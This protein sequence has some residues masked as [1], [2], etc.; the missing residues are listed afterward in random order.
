MNDI[1][2]ALERIYKW[3]EANLPEAASDLQPGLNSNEIN[4]KMSNIS[5]SLPQ[6]IYEI[7]SWRNGNIQWLR[8]PILGL[9]FPP[10]ETA[11]NTYLAFMEEPEFWNYKY[12]PI[13]QFDQNFDCVI[14]KPEKQIRSPILSIDKKSYL[15]EEEEED[16]DYYL[17]FINLTSMMLAIAECY[18]IGVFQIT[19]E[20]TIIGDNKSFETIRHKYNS[21]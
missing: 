2:K 13:F 16:F 19:A 5:M 8:Y 18:E 21:N 7:Y 15:L 9:G 17:S 12:F 20:G 1:Q 4:K 3:L 14:L 11:L 10:F 6:E